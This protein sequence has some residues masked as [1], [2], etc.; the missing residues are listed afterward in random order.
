MVTQAKRRWWKSPWLWA[1]LFVFYL[2]SPRMATTV[3]LTEAAP[4]QYRAEV[5]DVLSARRTDQGNVVACLLLDLKQDGKLY[6]HQVELPI[7]SLSSPEHPDVK[8]RTSGVIGRGSVFGAVVDEATM[9][10]GCADVPTDTDIYTGPN[11]TYG[12]GDADTPPEQPAFR[13]ELYAGKYPWELYYIAR[14]P[15]RRVRLMKTEV[16]PEEWREE[17]YIQFYFPPQQTPPRWWNLAWL[18][19][20]VLVDAVTGP[21]G[22]IAVVKQHG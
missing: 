15:L 8:Q 16:R 1:F 11:K 21:F 5:R 4:R 6:R 10:A 2:L 14:E 13:A 3:A 7:A 18:P 9:T 22:W 17:H 12:A 20:A 19:L